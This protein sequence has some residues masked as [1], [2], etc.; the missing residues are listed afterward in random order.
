MIVASYNKANKI[1]A[2]KHGELP[3]SPSLLQ[4]ETKITVM[5]RQRERTSRSKQ[6]E[7]R[8]THG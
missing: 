3:W 8:T 5:S 4:P 1:V 2:T 6:Y 7:H